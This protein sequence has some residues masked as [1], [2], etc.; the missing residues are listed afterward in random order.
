MLIQNAA[1]KQDAFFGLLLGGV[2]FSTVSKIL[3]FYMNMRSG[4]GD[5]KGVW[6]SYPIDVAVGVF[7]LIGTAIILY[8]ITSKL[9]YVH[10][11]SVKTPR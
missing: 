7:Q 9:F 10:H 6:F 1:L 8:A 2:A 3:D 5:F 4:I 11:Q